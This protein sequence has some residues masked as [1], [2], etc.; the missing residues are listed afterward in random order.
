MIISEIRLSNIRSH[1][2][3]TLKFNNGITVLS[4]RTGCGK[5][6]VFMSIAYALFGADVNLKNDAL[7]KRGARTGFVQLLFNN[8]GKEYEVT[9]GMKRS[10]KNI[11]T[12]PDK[13]SIKEDGVKIPIISRSNE[14]NEKILEVLNYPSDVKPKELFEITSY[15]RQDEI[16]KL[17][18]L[19][20][21]E[22]EKY[23]D[24][25]LQLSKYELTYENMKHLLNK[26]SNKLSHLK[27]RAEGFG[28][29]EQEVKKKKKELNE[30]TKVVKLINK[31]LIKS[32]DSL[33]K[34]KDEH[35]SLKEKVGEL[36]TKKASYDNKNGLLNGFIDELKGLE[37]EMNYYKG[38]ENVDLDSVT[39]LIAE[40]TAKK[41]KLVFEKGSVNGGIS[42]LKKELE[43]FGELKGKCPLCK[44][45]V[46]KEH[47]KRVKS[48]LLSKTSK[49]EVR[50]KEL[51]KELSGLDERILD[52]QEKKGLLESLSIKQERIKEL[53]EKVDYLKKE[54]VKLEP[55]VKELKLVQKEFTSINELFIKAS[56]K[57]SVLIE[58][59]VNAEENV[60]RIN[61]G[62]KE[63]LEEFKE[64]SDSKDKALKLG[65][66]IK[67]LTSLRRD[68]RSIRG[69]VRTRFLEDFRYG[70][71]R[72]YE[73]I[74]KDDNYSVEISNNYEP[75]AFAG[76]EETSINSLSGGE[77]TSVALSYRLALSE[78]A[79]K[80][81]SVDHNEL[82]L[83]DEPTT[84]FD[85]QDISTLPQALRAIKTIPQII[86]VSHEDELKEAADVNYELIKRNNTT[87]ING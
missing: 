73:D 59:K 7:L 66:K 29:I 69:V 16:R 40:L 11:I 15:A 64:L 75:L 3:T 58:K 24:R 23:I 36:E 5:S 70:F 84:G 74:R 25:V 45:E 8:N 14:L 61:Q 1:S 81:S 9:R 56:N 76:K 50:E 54:L 10:G 60:K 37:S 83:L 31:E 78:I 72:K 12:D 62:L 65:T 71:Q 67:L 77:K 79:A 2:G 22:R 55:I 43:G 53:N 47:L 52:S 26:L 63:S 19:T 18:E 46:G 42:E 51:I 28:N 6:T 4:G 20:K 82:L 48:D 35:E 21:G 49:L 57:N 30:L 32:E 87:I 39:K 34:I 38:L 13:L 27:G 41:T 44:Q 85:R 86:I 17:I 80:V 33:N 68:I